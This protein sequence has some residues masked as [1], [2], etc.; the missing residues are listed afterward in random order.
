MT[1]SGG[2]RIALSGLSL[3]FLLTFSHSVN[4]AYTNV[5]PV[6][7]P[8][9]QD[10]LG[11]GE[12][13][14]AVAVAVISLSSNV[15]QPVFGAFVEGWGRRRSAAIG[16][17]VGSVLMGFVSVAGSVW[18]LFFILAVGGLG[19]AC[20]HPA[21]A[22]LARDTGA[23]RGLSMSLFAAGGS[24]GV[25]VMPVVILWVLR[26]LGPDYVPLLSLG[27]VL[28]SLALLAF[29][30]QQTPKPRPAA[31]TRRSIDLS[32]LKGPVGALA[33]A[34]IL[35]AMAFISFTNGMPLFLANVR[36]FAADA[37]A[38]GL[39]LSIYSG[40][41]S[42]GTIL[43]GLVEARVGRLRLIV[44]CMLAA[45]PALLL[46]LVL[47]V[48]SLPYYLCVAL[49]GMLTNACIPMLVVSAQDLAP[50]NV[51]AA[52]GLLMGFTW[53]TAGV[54]YI[55]FGALQEAV[56][57]APAL[58]LGFAF[59]LPAV[60]LVTYVFKRNAAALAAADAQANQARA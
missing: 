57:I 52:S 7:L 25:A 33:A 46:T 44:T 5:L 51:A 27:G 37:P 49:G 20:F 26:T 9:L 14:L 58:A 60:A 32:L 47:D 21:A 36:G 35:R 3:T 43:A 24:L 18:S 29:T 4:D 45:L 41:A 59:L 23:R 8:T 1:V 34:G 40:A 50:D 48:G 42:A 12:A 15:L 16:L 22:S 11:L 28:F 30:P 10:R 38:I 56:G 55:G 54:L 17:L 13:V 19:S 31:G 53:G 2:R 39:T 6:F